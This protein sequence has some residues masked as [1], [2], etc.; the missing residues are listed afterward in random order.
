MTLGTRPA[1]HGGSN[2][3]HATVPGVLPPLLSP[4]GERPVQRAG[5]ACGR[6]WPWSPYH[7][8]SPCQLRKPVFVLCRPC[9]VA[10]VILSRLALGCTSTPVRAQ[11]RA[12]AA[13]RTRGS[14]GPTRSRPCCLEKEYPPC[15]RITP[16]TGSNKLKIGV[17]FPNKELHPWCGI[18]PTQHTGGAHWTWRPWL[19]HEL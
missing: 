2:L 5:P 14:C 18:T 15:R 7:R 12:A 13:L 4:R 8:L 1:I 9:G 16:T 10:S 17:M 11:D 19:G 3:C 6:L